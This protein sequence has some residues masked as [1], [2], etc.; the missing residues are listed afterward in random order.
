MGRTSELS[1]EID[2]LVKLTESTDLLKVL[3]LAPS[4]SSAKR[5]RIPQRRPGS[6]GSGK[7]SMTLLASDS[8]STPRKAVRDGLHSQASATSAVHRKTRSRR[9]LMQRL[10]PSKSGLSGT[11]PD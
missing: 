11:S 10:Q 3:E 9:L 6:R 4:M 5:I 1:G 2:G 7:P 8:R